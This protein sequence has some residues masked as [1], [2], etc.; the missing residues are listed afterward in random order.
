MMYIF[1]RYTFGIVV[2]N[3]YFN[4]FGQTLHPS[5]SRKIYMHYIVWRRL[6]FCSAWNTS[7]LQTKQNVRHPFKWSVLP[8]PNS[9]QDTWFENTTILQTRAKYSWSF[10]R[11]LSTQI[12]SRRRSR[13]L[14]LEVAARL[15]FFDTGRPT[16]VKLIVVSKV[17]R[18]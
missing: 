13:R 1:I 7:F 16:Q 12:C 17:W 15:F 6:T 14:D 3:N 18:T 5:T 9:E 4:K 11:T 2:I 8:H 10:Y